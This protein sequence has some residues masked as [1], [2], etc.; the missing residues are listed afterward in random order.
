MNEVTKSVLRRVGYHADTAR[1]KGEKIGEF[2]IT[3][4]E[5]RSIIGDMKEWPKAYPFM[6]DGVSIK[7]MW[8]EHA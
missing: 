4:S 8:N 7:I 1:I 3:E 2:E 6:I 5:F